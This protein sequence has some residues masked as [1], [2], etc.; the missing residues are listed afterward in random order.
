MTSK[1]VKLTMK[2]LISSGFVLWL[3]FKVN[4][5]EVLFYIKK[6]SF[7]SVLIYV[8]ILLSGMF[9]SAA[10]WKM[11]AQHKGIR[12]P[13]FSY[14]KYYLSGTFVNNFMPSFIGGDA[15]RAYQAGSRSGK[16]KE[17]VSSVV[18]DRITG[19]LGAL[20]LTAVFFAVNYQHIK[21]NNLLLMLELCVLAALVC[22]FVLMYLRGLKVWQFLGG[23]MP[24]KIKQLFTEISSYADHGGLIA[25]SVMWSLAFGMVGLA[26][27]NY[28]LFKSLGIEI[29]LADYL[30]VIFLIS[31]VSSI[32]ISIN[33]I[34][35]KE[36]SYLTFFG[37]FGVPSAS[38]VAVAIISRFL[39]ML[40]SFL[41]LPFYFN[42]RN[43]ISRASASLL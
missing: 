38:V 41:A 13:L 7:F 1:I 32:P 23:H 36:W 15:F 19:L 3:V 34:G 6:L 16:M 37:F 29:K 18:V 24:Q 4:W 33:N 22:F 26:A 28:A 30:S 43:K 8:L 42:G 40:V 39:Q 31:V 2:L 12:E 10:K 14:F 20:I 25:K 27:A 5:N 17:A 35:I 21:E 11:L 9:I